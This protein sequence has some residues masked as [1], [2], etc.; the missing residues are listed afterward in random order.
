[1]LF[2]NTHILMVTEKI[3]ADRLTSFRENNPAVQ[4]IRPH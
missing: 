1:M 4:N 2:G 3:G